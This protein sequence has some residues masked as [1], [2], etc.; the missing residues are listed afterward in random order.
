LASPDVA[1]AALFEQAGVIRTDTLTELFDVVDLLSAQPVPASGRV[2][3]VTNAG[4]LGILF[5]DAAEADRLTLPEPSPD[6]RA[7]L[8]AL[9]PHAAALANPVD[10]LATATPDQYEEA[11]ALVGGDPAFDAVV[12]IYIA[13]LAVRGEEI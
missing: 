3:V 9:L 6:T 5:A 7:G 1:V 13:P 8:G 11:I 12:V 2:G 4:G 10:L